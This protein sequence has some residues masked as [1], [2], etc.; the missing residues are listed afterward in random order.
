M[1]SVLTASLVLLTGALA[2]QGRNDN[3]DKKGVVRVNLDHSD[4]ESY[5]VVV[6][7]G[8]NREKV[9]LYLDTQGGDIS[10]PASNATCYQDYFDYEEAQS[11]NCSLENSFD[12]SLSSSFQ[13]NGSTPN[14]DYYDGSWGYDTVVVGGSE[15]DNVSLLVRSTFELDVE[16]PDGIFGIGRV[17]NELSYFHDDYTY[18]NL[19]LKMTSQGVINKAAYSI[20]LNASNAT[21]GE[22]LFGGV[23]HAKYE[24]QLTTVPM[25]KFAD[26]MRESLVVL[27]DVY[28][29]EQGVKKFDVTNS[30][31]Y[32]ASLN[33]NYQFTRFTPEVFDRFGIA[34]GAKVNGTSTLYDVPCF[35]ES[36]LSI[37]FNFSGVIIDVP[38]TDFLTTYNGSCVIGVVNQNIS[39]NPGYI[40]LGQN[41]LRNAYTVFD[42]EDE[43]VSLAQAKYTDDED[44]DVISDSIPSASQ[45]KYYSATSYNTSY[46]LGSVTTTL[47]FESSATFDSSIV[48]E[49]SSSTST[50]AHTGTATSSASNT[51]SS[52]SK[53]EAVSQC[54]GALGLLSVLLGY[55]SV[56]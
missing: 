3:N 49:T 53:G 54:V 18:D 19:P 22:L 47:S 34:L 14:S 29:S 55:L 1:K 20:F 16:E 48:T 44:I 28:V 30:N 40:S 2:L 41:F 4:H 31:P 7:L 5:K 23:D 15:V 32:L 51:N 11:T 46:S 25:I 17:E 21:S 45:A 52:K 36:D 6:E 9:T 37:G 27:H 50:P 24:G 39:Y 35:L 12:P 26:Q 43:T 42:F 56:F 8:S 10:V 38:Y 33:A 13:A